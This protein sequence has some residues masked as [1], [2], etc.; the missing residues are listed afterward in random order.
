MVYVVIGTLMPP[1]L[2]EAGPGAR[3]GP[4]GVCGGCGISRVVPG[5]VTRPTMMRSAMRVND[6]RSGMAGPA[7][8]DCTVF[9]AAGGAQ[10][11]TANNSMRAPKNLVIKHGYGTAR[12]VPGRDRVGV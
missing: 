1:P 8:E 12:L 7:S 10:A 2:V 11:A 6:D 4:I 5:A 3:N 9:G